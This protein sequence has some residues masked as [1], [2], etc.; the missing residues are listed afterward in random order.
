MSEIKTCE[1]YVLHELENAEERILFLE[2]QVGEMDDII[3]ELQDRMHKLIGDLLDVI[4]GYKKY[5]DEDLF[6]VIDKYHK[7]K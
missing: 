6:R 7:G 2:S 3:N 4:T 1:E 5:T